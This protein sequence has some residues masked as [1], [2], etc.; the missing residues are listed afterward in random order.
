MNT[1]ELH[2]GT[3]IRSRFVSITKSMNLLIQR[4]DDIRPELIDVS[5]FTEKHY[6]L[7]VETLEIEDHLDIWM[8]NRTDKIN[9]Q[10][11]EDMKEFWFNLLYYKDE[12]EIKQ[13]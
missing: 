13:R 4:R 2:Q 8:P 12:I 7:A 6:L 9:R 1:Q 11:Y 3:I 5:N 10:A